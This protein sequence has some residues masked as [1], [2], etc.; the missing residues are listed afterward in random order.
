VA[1]LRTHLAEVQ[2]CF[3]RVTVVF[4]VFRVVRAGRMFNLRS[5]R[6]ET[7]GERWNESHSVTETYVFDRISIFCPYHRPHIKESY[8]RCVGQLNSLE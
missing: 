5:V 4:V 3:V 7:N 8:P 2:L 6:T 1:Q